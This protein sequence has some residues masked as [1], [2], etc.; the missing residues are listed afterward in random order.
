MNIFGLH[1]HGGKGDERAATVQPLGAAYSVVYGGVSFG[2][3]SVVAYSIWAFR[4]LPD[5]GAMYATI[6]AVYI[7]LA[8]LAL[9]RLVQV[10]GAWKR[11]PLLFAL[12]F[13]VYAAC[14]CAFWFGLRGKMH[15]DL[16][17]SAVG[18][19]GMVI[20]FQ[21]AFGKTGAFLRLFMVLFAAHSVGYY[22]GGEFYGLVRGSTGRLLWGAAHGV[23]FG[24][25]LGYVLFDCQ[26]SLK[27]RISPA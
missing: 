14:W 27:A 10:P 1:S 18:L 25:G 4:L 13:F 8:G 23:G 15:A 17:G 6:A 5:A 22:L 21:R 24:A 12:G 26:E 20:V 19:A 3:V 9:S 7:G 16:L 2:V 11:F